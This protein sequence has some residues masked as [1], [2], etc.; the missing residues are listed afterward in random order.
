M[1]ALTAFNLQI[2][3]RNTIVGL[4]NVPT[5][6]KD[7]ARGMGQT[8]RQILWRVEVPLA[9]P[10]II[11][12]L[13]IATVSTVA[14]ATLA[15]LR[16]RRRPRRADLRDGINFKTNIIIAGGIAILMALAFDAILLR[17]P[18][19]GHALGT[20]GAGVIAALLPSLPLGSIEG[21][22]EFIFEPQPSNV[23]GGKL[24]G[25]F[26]QTLELALTQL[27][28]TVFALA[29]SLVVALPARPLPRAQG[30]R[31]AARDRPRQRRPGDPR[32]GADRLHGGGDRRRHRST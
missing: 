15:A 2:I 28:V 10:E 16:R 11:A 18:A 21:A 19:A 20:G 8:D 3:Y 32:A 9:T 13:R 17:D 25:G 27:E 31:R 26:D 7:A 29:L 6:V 5:S 22:I 30:G 4:A 23:T 24:V 12:G 1:I 14:I